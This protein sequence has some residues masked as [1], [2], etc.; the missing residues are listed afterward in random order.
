MLPWSFDDPS[1]VIALTGRAFRH[2]YEEKEIDPLVFNSVIAKG[3]VYARM[4]P[5]DKT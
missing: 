4:S 5:D 2:I 1:I 3:K